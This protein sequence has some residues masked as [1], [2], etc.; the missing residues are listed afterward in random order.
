MFP[1]SARKVSIHAV[2]HIAQHSQMANP[3]VLSSFSHRSKIGAIH[4]KKQQAQKS[5][6]SRSQN[7]RWFTSMAMPSMNLPSMALPSISAALPSLPSLSSLSPRAMTERLGQFVGAAAM[8][9][10]NNR[11]MQRVWAKRQKRLHKAT[12]SVMAMFR[13]EAM[14]FESA[15]IFVRTAGMFDDAEDNGQREVHIALRGIAHTVVLLRESN[16]QRLFLMDRVVEGIRLTELALSE[17]GAIEKCAHFKPAEMLRL[18]MHRNLALP[19]ADV[20]DW[21]E[22]E[23]KNEYNVITNSCVNFA[24]F[25]HR[26]FL[27]GLKR[28]QFIEAV[29]GRAQTE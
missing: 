23:G 17:S 2:S 5:P 15:E 14:S 1:R 7:G 28:R 3:T 24:Y 26:H 25:F 27:R 6:S 12:S 18:S 8:A 4:T 13:A 19:A 16:T 20:A 9:N 22:A 11:V 21:V 10:H 29:W